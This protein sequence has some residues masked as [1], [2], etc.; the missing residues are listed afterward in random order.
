MYSIDVR[1]A[2]LRCDVAVSLATFPVICCSSLPSVLDYPLVTIAMCTAQ[3]GTLSLSAPPTIGIYAVMSSVSRM[4]N[5]RLPLHKR[6]QVSFKCLLTV[7]KK[8]SKSRSSFVQDNSDSHDKGVT[9]TNL[10]EAARSRQ[11]EEWC[12]FGEEDVKNCIVSVLHKSRQ[13]GP[14]EIQA[15]GSAGAVILTFFICDCDAFV[16]FMHCNFLCKGRIPRSLQHR[17]QRRVT[18]VQRRVSSRQMLR[19]MATTACVDCERVVAEL[20]STF[21]P[22]PP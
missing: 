4:A 5:P 9:R 22:T 14:T 21:S 20:L 16:Q 17:T 1:E 3:M 19:A 12:P 11:T 10:D 8:I 18:G 7:L 2:Q 15:S 13:G 6:R